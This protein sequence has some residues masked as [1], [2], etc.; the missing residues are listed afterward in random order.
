VPSSAETL[1]E[2]QSAWNIR[3]GRC[4]GGLDLD[5]LQ[6]RSKHSDRSENAPKYAVDPKMIFLWR[7][8]GPKPLS[9][10]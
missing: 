6:C 3:V 5:V 4:T 10:W 9:E 8:E 1:I 7:G 2:P